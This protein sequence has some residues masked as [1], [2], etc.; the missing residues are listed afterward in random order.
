MNRYHNGKIYKLVNADTRIYVGS[1]CLPLS[2]R[3]SCHKKAGWE[4]VRIVQIE[5]FRCE[6]K[7]ELVAR[8]QFYIDLLKP[9]LNM[10]VQNF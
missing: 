2:K 4:N 9:S 8:E 7:Q 10:L 5:A 3:L 6:T 1:T